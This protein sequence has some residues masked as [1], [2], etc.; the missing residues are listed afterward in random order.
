MDK[1][2]LIITVTKKE[3]D[4][5]IAR[6]FRDVTGQLKGIVDDDYEVTFG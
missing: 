1:E 5:I 3:S 2:E 4:E 6:V